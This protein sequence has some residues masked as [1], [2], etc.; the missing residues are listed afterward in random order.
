MRSQ[1]LT[2]RLIA[3]VGKV[4]SRPLLDFVV[5]R[6]RFLCCARLN[7]TEARYTVSCSSQC[8]FLRRGVPCFNAFQPTESPLLGRVVNVQITIEGR[9]R[10]SLLSSVGEQSDKGGLGMPQLRFSAGLC[11]ATS[12]EPTAGGGFPSV[13]SGSADNPCGTHSTWQAHRKTW[14][15]SRHA[16]PSPEILPSPSTSKSLGRC[17]DG[18]IRT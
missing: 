4:C 3:P 15:P 1:F 10:Q 9:C 6:L 2:K 11:S 5:D 8:R 7:K 12:L 16:Y 17:H 18:S 14:L 13:K